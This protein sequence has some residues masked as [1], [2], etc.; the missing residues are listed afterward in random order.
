[1]EIENGYQNSILNRLS[2]Q[3]MD[4]CD[5]TFTCNGG[6]LTEFASWY[7]RWGYAIPWSNTNA[8]YV[9]A[10]VSATATKSSMSCGSIIASPNYLIPLSLKR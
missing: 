6:D 1:M 5:R 10:N 9:D 2:I 7:R 3:E 8:S 4:S